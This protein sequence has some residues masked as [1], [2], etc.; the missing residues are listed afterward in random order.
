MNFRLIG[1][2]L[3]RT[4]TASLQIALGQLLGG[5]VYLMREIPGH[6]FPW[7]NRRSEWVQ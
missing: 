6:P 1:A 4:G 2:G 5:R 7:V 3:P